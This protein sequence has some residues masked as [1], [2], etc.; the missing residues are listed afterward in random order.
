MEVLRK[1]I[2]LMDPLK[3][4]VFV[5][6]SGEIDIVTE[7][8]KYHGFKA[9]RIHGTDVKLDRKKTMEDFRSGK[10]QILVASDLAARGLD[11]GE[12]THIFNLSIPEE[13]MAYLHRAG[14]TGRIGEAGIV[15]SLVSKPELQ[16]VRLFEKDLKIR[17]TQKNMHHGQISDA[18]KDGKRF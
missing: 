9:E 3:A 8:L 18:I 4:I 13:S 7:K 1:L 10:L 17:I 5:A 12:I 6:Q 14:R 2:K 11:I 16:Y 15:V